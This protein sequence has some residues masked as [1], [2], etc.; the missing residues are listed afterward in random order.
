MIK[1]EKTDSIKI[2]VFEEQKLFLSDLE[3]IKKELNS[4]NVIAFDIY[5]DDILIGF[6]MLK[7]FKKNSFFLWDYAI[8]CKYQNKGYG[9]KT[10]KELI[11]FL[12]E[13]YNMKYM[14][15]TYKIGNEVAKHIYEKIGFIQTDIVDEENEVNMSYKF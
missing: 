11:E 5:D 1:F 7:E 10:L 4:K 12:R 3:K 13:K 15:T 6:V 14:T 9:Y 2:T 8:D